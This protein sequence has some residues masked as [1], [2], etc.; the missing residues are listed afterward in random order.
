MRQTFVFAFLML[1]L[2]APGARGVE[3]PNEP[4]D[5]AAMQA[6]AANNDFAFALYK[7]LATEGGDRALFFSPLSIV[8]ALAIAAEGARGETADE[9]GK[10]LRLPRALRQAGAAA[11]ER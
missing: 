7:R 10:A 5:K 8:S 6:A 1:A 2:I 4:V 11:R 3:S 9:M